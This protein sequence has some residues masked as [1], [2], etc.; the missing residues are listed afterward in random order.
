MR[1]VLQRT[2]EASV[3]IENKKISEIKKGLIIFLGVEEKDDFSDINWLVNKVLSLRIFSDENNKMNLSVEQVSGEIMVVSQF[4]LHAKVKKGN[5]P[6]FIKSARSDKANDLY[7][8]FILELSKV[9]KC[10]VKKGK[11][12]ADMKVAIVNDGPVTILID[13]KNKE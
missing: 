12:G 7:E 5:R 10:K 4:T 13:S 3:S 11:F 9:Y 2:S 8:K 6:S 1:L